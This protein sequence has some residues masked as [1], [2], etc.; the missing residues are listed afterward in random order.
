MRHASAATIA[1]ALALACGATGHAALLRDNLYRVR[2]TSPEE[3]G[4]AGKSGAISRT[5]DAGKTW[6]A[7]DSGTQEPLFGVDFA[8]GQHA[9]AVGKSALVIHTDDGGKTW[10]PQRT[11]L[12]VEKHLF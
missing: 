12:S 2:A 4:A 10:K 5:T 3:A 6:Q 8:D 9:W 1:L 7:G 11:P